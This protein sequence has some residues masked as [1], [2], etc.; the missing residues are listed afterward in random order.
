VQIELPA[1]TEI[2]VNADDAAGEWSFYL[3][4]E[5]YKPLLEPV[6]SH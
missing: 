1:N 4:T 6:L 3:H 2:T 5:I